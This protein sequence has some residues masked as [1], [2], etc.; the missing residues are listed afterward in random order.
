MTEDER[1]VFKRD[2]D[3]L[4]ARP[5]VGSRKMKRVLVAGTDAFVEAL[6]TVH[7]G[8]F[9]FRTSQGNGLTGN[10]VLREYLGCEIV[11]DWLGRQRSSSRMD[12]EGTVQTGETVFVST[13]ACKWPCS[14]LG[15]CP[16]E[17][18]T[19]ASMFCSIA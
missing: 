2:N 6:V 8:N 13:N 7:E 11:W 19:P 10:I 15:I 12:Y 17:R 1:E 14:N 4:D 18:S 9:R 3:A 5:E 16:P